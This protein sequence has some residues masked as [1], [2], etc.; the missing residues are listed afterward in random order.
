[1]DVR[2]R[3]TWQRAN[4]RRRSGEGLDHVMRTMSSEE[5]V[6]A[7]A[8]AG[9]EDAV[10]ANAIATAILNRMHQARFFGAALGIALVSF[11]GGLFFLAWDVLV[12]GALGTIEHAPFELDLVALGLTSLGTALVAVVGAL[13]LWRRSSR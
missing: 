4:E 10:A 6:E 7:L 8:G 5:L 12:S 3:R 2:F 13:L 9:G 11:V 1:M